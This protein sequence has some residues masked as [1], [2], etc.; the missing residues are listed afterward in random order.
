[1][2][3][4]FYQG[5]EQKVRKGVPGVHSSFYYRIKKFILPVSMVLILVVLL[6][7]SLITS[8]NST[9]FNVDK[10]TVFTKRKEEKFIELLF[11]SSHI[12]LTYDEFCKQ[13]DIRMGLSEDQI[14]MLLKQY[15]YDYDFEIEGRSWFLAIVNENNEIIAVANSAGEIKDAFKMLAREGYLEVPEDE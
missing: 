14:K 1:M 10:L 6:T 4:D 13:A 9:N 15:E 8:V 2:K 12:G 11:K 5:L 3:K 7:S